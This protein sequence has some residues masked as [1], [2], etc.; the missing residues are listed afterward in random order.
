MA[1]DQQ[2]DTRTPEQKAAEEALAKARADTAAQQE[3]N[4]AERSG[5][6]TATPH[7]Q[8][9]A[10]I[11]EDERRA[12]DRGDLGDVAPKDDKGNDKPW[13]SDPKAKRMTFLVR[14]RIKG[15]VQGRELKIGK[16]YVLELTRDIK[17]LVRPGVLEAVGDADDAPAAE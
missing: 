16:T 8:A 11:S 13:K 14:S 3:R 2:R 9:H 17:D 12:F 4:R 10:E 1:N 6:P 5:A 7:E 15:T